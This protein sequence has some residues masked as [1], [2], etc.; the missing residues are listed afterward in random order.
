MIRLVSRASRA[1]PPAA[2]ATTGAP[3]RDAPAAPPAHSWRRWLDE[4]GTLTWAAVPLTLGQKVLVVI[5]LSVVAVLL[6][7]RAAEFL[8]GLQ[9]D[10]E[11]ESSE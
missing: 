2:A 7:Y 6:V 1:L 9:S 10:H 8:T 5:G 4:G 3:E 11:Q